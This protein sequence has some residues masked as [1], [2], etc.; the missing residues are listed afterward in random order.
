MA[1]TCPASSRGSPEAEPD[2]FLPTANPEL[3]WSPV[4]P[5]DLVGSQDAKQLRGRSPDPTP[6]TASKDISLLGS[7]INKNVFL[8]FSPKPP[9]HNS[10]RPWLFSLSP[11]GP[12]WQVCL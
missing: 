1:V 3:S 12:P 7:S 8:G 10:F 9:S 5:E 11:S 4:S 6:P 2:L